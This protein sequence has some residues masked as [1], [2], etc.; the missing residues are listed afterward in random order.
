LEVSFI[1]KSEGALV[2]LELNFRG[3]GAPFVPSVSFRLMSE[4]ALVSLELDFRGLGAP[5]SPS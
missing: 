4:G 2:S 5:F 1:L 3:L